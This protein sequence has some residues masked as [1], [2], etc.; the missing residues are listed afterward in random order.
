MTRTRAVA[1]A[2]GA[3][4]ME[5]VEAVGHRQAATI[6]TIGQRSSTG[7][8]TS[9]AGALAAYGID[10]ITATAVVVVGAASPEW[11]ECC[12]DAS[13]TVA[14]WTLVGFTAGISEPLVEASTSPITGIGPGAFFVRVESNSDRCTAAVGI[15]MIGIA[16]VTGLETRAI[17]AM[18][19]HTQ[20][21]LAPRI[22]RTWRAQ[23]L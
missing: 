16:R 20:F 23:R 5:W 11:V 15:G 18:P 13:R 12:A 4:L 22:T 21:T 3:T 17:A 14:Q 10:T 9:R 8:A 6:H 7:L 1:A 2:L 19:M